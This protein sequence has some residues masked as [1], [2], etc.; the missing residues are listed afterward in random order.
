MAA[1]YTLGFALQRAVNITNTTG[2]TYGIGVANYTVYPPLEQL[3]KSL[4]SPHDGAV[5]MVEDAQQSEG[6]GIG[7]EIRVPLGALSPTVAS[8]GLRSTS[9]SEVAE[10]KSD[11]NAT[12]GLEAFPSV[13]K[14]RF[15]FVRYFL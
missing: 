2:K 9:R 1:N 10:V 8:G 13:P 7:D 3:G 11:I 5:V 4:G 12:R 15:T 14:V 6:R